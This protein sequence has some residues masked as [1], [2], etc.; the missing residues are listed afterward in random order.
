MKLNIL[1]GDIRLRS[2]L[3]INQFSILTEKPFVYTILAFIQSH[4]RPLGKINGYFQFSPGT[5]KK[6]KK[7]N[8]IA[9]SNKVCLKCNCIN[10]S[11]VNGIREPILYNFAL[12]KPPGRKIYKESRIKLFKKIYKPVLS[13]RIFYLEDNDLKPVDF[14]G[15]TISKTF[16]LGKI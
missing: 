10:G 16:Q 11:I 8:H 3:N 4:S 7:T 1:T 6:G 9:G 15:E 5:Y 14:N 2:K 13:Q 12:K